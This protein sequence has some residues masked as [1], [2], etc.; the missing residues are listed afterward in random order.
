[1]NKKKDQRKS[2]TSTVKE[3]IESMLDSF[4][5]KSK[6]QQTQLINS[7]SKIMGEPIARRTSNL[8]I[9]DR[10]L[11]VTLTSAPLKHELTIG[12]KKIIEM[13]QKEFGPEVVDEVIFR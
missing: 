10:T 11:F 1:M 3:A 4:R 13:L 8:Y 6:F 9:Q 5:L 7:W 12:K 2:D